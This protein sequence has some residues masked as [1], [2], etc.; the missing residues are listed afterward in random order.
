MSIPIVDHISCYNC[1]YPHIGKVENWLFLRNV[2]DIEVYEVIC[3]WIC[4]YCEKNPDRKNCDTRNQ[5]KP[6]YIQS[7]IN[8]C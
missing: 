6:N 7:D 2:T 4:L 8:D 1:S 3:Q 5:R